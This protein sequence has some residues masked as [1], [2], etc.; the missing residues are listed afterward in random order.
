M[1]GLLGAVSLALVALTGV[2]SAQ[3]TAQPVAA[4]HEQGGVGFHSFQAPLGGR[5]WL[6]Q[7][8]AIDVGL[9]VGSE[10]VGLPAGESTSLS[11]WALDL[12]VPITMRKYDRLYVLFRP[13]ILYTS[14]EDVT[15]PGPPVVKDSDT[16]MALNL[17]IEAEVFL[18]DH[19]SVSAS[20]GLAFVSNSPAQGESTT[21]WGTTG[22]NFTT[23]GFHVYMFGSKK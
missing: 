20:T 16:S 1:K 13:G 22:S 7:K 23:V 21:D 6:N 3:G 17:E 8:F 14:Q 11:S 5:W 15:D 10:E 18:T 9:G 2:A 12:G 4:E 19:F